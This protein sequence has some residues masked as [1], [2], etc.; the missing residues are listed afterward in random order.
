VI[1]RRVLTALVVAA[2]VLPVAIVVVGA[3][4]RLLAAM[5]DT[6][7]AA[8]LDGI[9]LALGILWV[10]DLVCLVLVQ[11]INSLGPPPD[12]EVTRGLV[13]PD[14]T[15]TRAL[16]PGSA[17]ELFVRNA[18]TPARSTESPGRAGG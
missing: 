8:V 7:G 12:A 13:S 10:I 15:C 2:C 6:T 17:G 9:A 1:S 3:V 18:I 4:G 11:A 5:A 14:S 16:A